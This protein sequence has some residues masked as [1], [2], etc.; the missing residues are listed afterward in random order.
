M[1]YQGSSLPQVAGMSPLRQRLVLEAEQVR[2]AR[3][4]R[5]RYYKPYMKQRL[6]HIHGRV[7]RERMLKAGNQQG[8]TLAAA[9]EVAMH[10]T[11]RYPD[12]WAG[13]RYDR[14]IAAWAAGITGESTRDNPQRLLLGRVGALGTGFIPQADIDGE[15][16]AARGVAGLM[17]TVLVAHVSGGVSTLMF[18]SYEKGAAKWQGETLDLIWF[19]EEPPLDVYSEGLTRTQ[20]T[21]GMVIVTYTPLLGM[22]GVTMRYLKEPSPERICVSMTIYDAGHYTDD[23]RAKII[24]GYP[25]HEREARAFGIPMMGSGRIFPV[26]Q[27]AISYTPFVMPKLWPRIKGM[28]FGWDHPTAAA[29]LAWDR[30]NDLIYVY[31]AYRMKEQPV[32]VHAMA[33][34]SN[35]PWVPVAWPHDGLQHD[36]GSGLVLAAQYRKAEVPMLPEHAQFE[37]TDEEGES[38]VSRTSVEAGVSEMLTRFQNGTLKIAS[39]LAEVFEEISLYHRKDGKIAKEGDDLISAIRYAMM[40]LRYAKQEPAAIDRLMRSGPRRLAGGLIV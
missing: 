24:A 27:D 32:P 1:A 3:T 25:A 11:G 15:P 28:D 23:E 19:D 7:Y 18:K 38:R 13:R 16:T 30:D 35:D 40:M 4:N 8:K 26:A 6:F 21:G 14:P 10:L 20:A 17:D 31:H 34:R 12:W 5:L 9:A 39:H 29:S 36:K 22:S 2:R 33:I 37:E